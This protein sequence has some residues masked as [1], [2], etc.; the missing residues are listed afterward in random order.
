[1]YPRIGTSRRSGLFPRLILI[2]LK[3]CLALSTFAAFTLA[4]TQRVFG[5]SRTLEGLLFGLCAAA[6]VV[7]AIRNTESFERTRVVAQIG[8]PI[9]PLFPPPIPLNATGANGH[10]GIG[11]RIIRDGAQDIALHSYSQGILYGSPG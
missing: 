8:K 11:H 4:I 10:Y 2:E 3:C 5:A 6:V 7:I 9:A 1:M